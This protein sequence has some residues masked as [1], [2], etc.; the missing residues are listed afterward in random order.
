MRSDDWEIERGV[1]ISGLFTRQGKGYG[2][3]SLQFWSSPTCK[4]T[5]SLHHF[6]PP[7]R[8]RRCAGWGQAQNTAIL[9][10]LSSLL[11]PIPS[12]SLPLWAY[13]Y[14]P[15]F[16]LG[17]MSRNRYGEEGRKTVPGRE[18][19]A[20]TSLSTGRHMQVQGDGEVRPVS[21]N[22]VMRLGRAAGPDHGQPVHPSSVLLRARGG[23]GH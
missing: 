1:P 17:R 19:S 4:L 3:N 15:F 10:H 16:V 13:S 21:W 23:T 18:A 6:P 14:H 12:N 5:V 9:L 11:S 2:A 22:D 20:C 8:K 7:Q